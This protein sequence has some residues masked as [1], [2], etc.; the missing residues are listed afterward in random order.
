MLD[1]IFLVL[2]VAE[3]WQG[4]SQCWPARGPKPAVT[5]GFQLVRALVQAQ[6]LWCQ[7]NDI[8]HYQHA[9]KLAASSVCVLAA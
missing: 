7:H 4:S 2:T 3:T 6:D 1:F 9:N 8:Y 5:D